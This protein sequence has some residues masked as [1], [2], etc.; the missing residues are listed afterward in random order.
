MILMS[1]LVNKTGAW[2]HRSEGFPYN[3]AK[4]EVFSTGY[5]DDM[6]WMKKISTWEPIMKKNGSMSADEKISGPEGPLTADEINGKG[7]SG[8]GLVNPNLGL[9]SNGNNSNKK[10]YA[11]MDY[12]P[13]IGYWDQ[14]KLAQMMMKKSKDNMGDVYRVYTLIKKLGPPVMP[15]GKKDV[16]ITAKGSELKLS[17]SY[18]PPQ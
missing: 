2:T 12:T 18:N 17:Y 4:N 8:N 1:G 10:Y 9:K 16:L 15:N 3:G 5:P 13:F 7:G 14:M 6:F 11:L